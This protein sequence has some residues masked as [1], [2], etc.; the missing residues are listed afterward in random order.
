MNACERLAAGAVT[1][2]CTHG[3]AR[4]SAGASPDSM[5]GHKRL[6][7]TPPPSRPRLIHIRNGAPKAI[8]N[9]SLSAQTNL[10]IH[11]T[12]FCRVMVYMPSKLFTTRYRISKYAADQPSAHSRL[13]YVGLS[14]LASRKRP[15][16]RSG[17]AAVLQLTCVRCCATRHG[18]CENTR[19][20]EI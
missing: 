14:D 10:I 4:D 3:T 1:H 18:I 8:P 17:K 12:H 2:T 16:R 11:H 9:T 5:H 19:R 13:V 6:R 15:K 7:F 20:N